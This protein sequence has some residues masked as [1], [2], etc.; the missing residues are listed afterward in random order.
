M[1]IPEYVRRL[2]EKIGRDLLLVPTAGAVIYDDAGR[3][4]LAHH[5]GSGVW[6]FPGGIVEPLEAPA[7]AAVREVWEE[8]GLSVRPSR[9][10]GV[11]GGKEFR[12]AYPNGDEI[13]YVLTLFECRIVSG[14]LR[15][16]AE[17]IDAAEYVSLDRIP[18]LHAPRFMP[19]VLHDL[20]RGGEDARFQAPT[21]TPDELEIEGGDQR[22]M[23]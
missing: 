11:Y 2:R 12:T 15:P 18:N 17:E 13:C 10:V 22:G 5:L 1:P 8:T 19:V 4:L 3:V 20:N 23:I 6:S 7:D 9:L 14:E 21:W 16:D